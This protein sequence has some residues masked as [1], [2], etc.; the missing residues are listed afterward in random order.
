MEV[1]YVDLQWLAGQ[2][3]SFYPC[4]NAILHN[5]RGKEDLQK[6]FREENWGHG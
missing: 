2:G 3:F 6:T 5:T 4:M 1:E